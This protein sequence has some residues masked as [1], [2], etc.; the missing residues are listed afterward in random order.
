MLAARVEPKNGRQKSKKTGN[1]KPLV[2]VQ[3]Q[4][5]VDIGVIGIENS[6]RPFRDRRAETLPDF[7]REGADVVRDSG[8]CCHHVESHLFPPAVLA[9][10]NLD[11]LAFPLL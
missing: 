7:T 3:F 10:G 1:F 6:W 8:T 11:A 2:L 4:P 5:A 9:E